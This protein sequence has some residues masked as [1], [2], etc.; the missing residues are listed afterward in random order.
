MAEIFTLIPEYA[1]DY[2]LNWNTLQ[3]PF[4]LGYVQTRARWP[5]AKRIFVLRWQSLNQVEKEY[6]ESFFINQVGAAGS[7]NYLLPD[8]IATPDYPGSA[9][10]VAG[11]ALGSRT[12]YYGISWLTSAGETRQSV[13]RSIAISVNNLFSITVPRFP[14][15]VTSV[16]LYV[17]QDFPGIGHLEG[18]STVSGVTF[19]EPTSGYTALG[20]FAPLTN[21]ASVTALVHL[22]DDAIPLSKNHAGVYS[23]ELK[24]EEVL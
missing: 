4:D 21:T 16:N 7:F 5:F 17:G 8:P 9:V 11:G 13:E 3:T 14:A 23:G 2:V 12:Y 18:T 15:Y 10:Q 24:F 22:M 19:T 20:A 6:I 1:F